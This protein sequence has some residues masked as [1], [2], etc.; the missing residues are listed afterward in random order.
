MSKARDVFGHLVVE[1]SKTRISDLKEFPRYVVECLINR[2]CPGENFEAE[3]AIVR[4]KLAQHYASPIDRDRILYQARDKGSYD[5]IARVEATL[6]LKTDEYVGAIP[7][8]NLK[9]LEVPEALLNQYPR[10]IGGLW[11]IATLQYQRPDPNNPVPKLILSEFDPFQYG[12]VDIKDFEARR[13]EFSRQEWMDLLV[14]TVGLNP[15]FYSHRQK[16]LILARLVPMTERM[17][18][19]IELGPRETG[20]SYGYKNLSYYAYMLSGG[21]ATPAALFVHGG[22]GMPGLVARFDA[23]VF[24]EIA[25][26]EFKDPQATVS[27]FK[28][29][30]EYGNFTLGKYP[31]KGESSIV[32]IGNINVLG[33]MPHEVYEHLLEPLP[34]EF[35]DTALFERVHGFIPGWEMP[36]LEDKSFASGWGFTLDYFAEVLHLLRSTLLPLDPTTRYKLYKAKSRDSDATGKI[37]KGLVKLLHPD[38]QVSDEELLEYVGL[39]VEMRQR[40]K[41]QLSV[42]A[43]GEYPH[44]TM[45]YEVGSVRR[46]TAP[47]E[48]AR[49][50]AV[51]LPATPTVGIAVGLVVSETIGGQIQIIEIEAYPGNGEP[52]IRGNVRAIM[53]AS[54]AAA[55]DAVRSMR[56]K[57]AICSEFKDGFHVTALPCQMAL[58]K[59]GP[60]AGLVF[61][62]GIASALTKQP[63]PNDW[64]ATGELTMKGF[65]QGIGGLAQKLD[66]AHKAGVKKV[67]VPKDNEKEFK[68][69]PPQVA[70]SMQVVFVSTLEEAL[71][72][73]GWVK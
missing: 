12:R 61:A 42:L 41:D 31:V 26:T 64:A 55:N 30:M 1:K 17:V 20:K 67:L 25:N 47:P 37:V 5:L 19:L 4:K 15:D 24:D 11:G 14:N 22:N 60:S 69:L 66:A 40:V 29:F 43:P 36:K 32:M 7:S 45:E 73:L 63:V 28:D 68:E 57:L 35:I 34:A 23:L 50:R 3:L 72:V 52:R 56:T 62:I 70:G 33:N 2:F 21:R 6:D 51:N 48:R 54:L 39:A 18:H 16:L 58:P 46:L 10:L 49:R 38:G 13:R 65:V 44:G 71:K 27:I 9:D 8:L 59:D 53:K